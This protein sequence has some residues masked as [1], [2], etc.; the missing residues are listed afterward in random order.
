MGFTPWLQVRARRSST[1]LLRSM[2][3]QQQTPLLRPPLRRPGTAIHHLCIRISR[4]V[5]SKTDA[6]CN[7]DKPLDRFSSLHPDS[8]RDGTGLRPPSGSGEDSH[9]GRR[10]YHPLRKPPPP[11]S[12]APPLPS[13]LLARS[14]H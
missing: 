9:H 11:P 6:W 13:F 1:A 10:R 2:D 12:P 4:A 3:H 7:S 8:S 5:A 14:L